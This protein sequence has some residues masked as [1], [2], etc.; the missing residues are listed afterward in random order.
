MLKRHAPASGIVLS[1]I[2]LH[3]ATLHYPGGSQADKQ[4]PGFSWRHNY[5]SNLFDVAAVNGAD[6]PARPWAVAGVF[7]LCAGLASFF[8]EF[9]R[10]IPAPRPARII[11]Y[12]GLGAI[13]CAFFTITPYHD[14][15]LGCAGTLALFSMFYVTI[16]VFRS[17][18]FYLKTLCL[19]CLLFFC[20][21]NYVYY[22]KHFLTFLPVMQKVNFL[23]LVS[24]MLS[25]H[26]FSRAED[27]SAA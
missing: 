5:L 8:V 10:K 7:F 22:T 11:K 4:A 13:I 20:A 25:L 2:L 26:Y 9:P 14:V 18:L 1:L 27:F 3:I 19:V 21:C 6:N 15:L 12:A 16:F 23:L 17:R 24:W